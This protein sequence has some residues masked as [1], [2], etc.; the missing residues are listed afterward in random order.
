MTAEIACILIFPRPKYTEFDPLHRSD[1][2][3]SAPFPP[4][5]PLLGPLP[6]LHLLTLKQNSLEKSPAPTAVHVRLTEE[7]LG[8]RGLRRY[9]AFRVAEWSWKVAE[10]RHVSR[11]IPQS[12][13]AAELHFCDIPRAECASARP[14]LVI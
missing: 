7:A 14:P 6:A 10:F 4:R 1:T 13:F 3:H 9:A 12:N 5:Y 11:D 2:Q 8:F